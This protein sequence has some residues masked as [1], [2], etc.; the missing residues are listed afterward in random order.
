MLY[1]HKFREEQIEALCLYVIIYRY[2]DIEV[3]FF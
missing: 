1:F 3:Y 2:I